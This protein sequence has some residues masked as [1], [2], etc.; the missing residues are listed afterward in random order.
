MDL[1]ILCITKVEQHALPFLA[2]MQSVSRLLDAEFVIAADGDYAFVRAENQF[3]WARVVQVE[4]KGYLESVHDEAIDHCR[5]RMVLRLDDDERCSPA[6]VRW[7]RSRDYRLHDH[8]KFARAAM[9]T[10]ETF[11]SSPQL[12]PDHQT[13]LSSK[14]KA[15]GRNS[16]HAASPHGGGFCAPVAIEHHK[17]IVKTMQQRQA[18]ADNYDRIWAGA[19]SNGMLAFQLPELAYGE[20]MPLAAWNDGTVIYE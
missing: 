3:A 19:G 1:A 7:L 18:I 2:E 13:R 8:W 4:S 16:L 11:I 10:R 20:H 12:W 9:W 6:M 5:A 14:E 17:F 15:K